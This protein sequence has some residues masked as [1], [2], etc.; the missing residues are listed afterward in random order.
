MNG[1]R[2]PAELL[3]FYAFLALWTAGTAHAQLTG[4][5]PRTA[6]ARAA[7][8]DRQIAARGVSDARVLEAMR[9][10]RRH[11]FVPPDVVDLAY[12]D[13]PLPIGLGQTISQPYIVA[14]MTELL[15]VRP[16]DRVLEVGTGSGYQAAILSALGAEVYTVEIKEGLFDEAAR[17][18]AASAYAGVRVRHG[19][20]YYGWPEAAPFAG[21]II[22]AAVDHVPPPLLAQLAAGGRMVLPLGSPYSYLGQ[23]LVVVSHAPDGPLVR[24]VLAVRFVPMTGRAESPR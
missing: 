16:G 5:T 4:D 9:A 12:N 22:T 17:R 13:T 10:V 20:G 8:V 19:D 3:A 23:T 21:I 18:L 14:L 7:M 1:H 2:V 11:E 6:R 15:G 24:Q